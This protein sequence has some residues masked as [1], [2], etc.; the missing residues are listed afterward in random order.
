VVNA[1]SRPRRVVVKQCT[2][3][4]E[5]TPSFEFREDGRQLFP[6]PIKV[7]IARD[8]TIIAEVT[9]RTKSAYTNYTRAV[10]HPRSTIV[11][12]P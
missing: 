5:L 1:T 9:W 12:H 7:R 4:P 6:N 11:R 3:E 8:P 10:R 2:T